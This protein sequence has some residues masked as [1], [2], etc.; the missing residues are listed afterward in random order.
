MELWKKFFNKNREEPKAFS[1]D[2]ANK[3]T[4]NNEYQKKVIALNY[5]LNEIHKQTERGEYGIDLNYFKFYGGEDKGNFNR[6]NIMEFVKSE[7]TKMGY[8]CGEIKV[9]NWA[10]IYSMRVRWG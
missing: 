7:L 9:S 3:L 1:K 8:N 10:S 2:E 5:A 6:K 4:Q